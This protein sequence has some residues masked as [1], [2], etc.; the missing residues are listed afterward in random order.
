MFEA[1]L[2]LK[3]IN[4]L[5]KNHQRPPQKQLQKQRLE[6]FQ[7]HAPEGI[8]QAQQHPC[9]FDH[10]TGAEAA[11]INKKSCIYHASTGKNM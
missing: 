10:E 7:A 5:Y 3:N 2:P 8:S 11:N 6:S 1:Y 9:N 4:V